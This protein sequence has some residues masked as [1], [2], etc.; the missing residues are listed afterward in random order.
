V[1]IFQNIGSA[2]AAIH[3]TSLDQVHLHELGGVDT[4]VDVVGALVGLQALEVNYIVSSPVPL[5]RGFIRGAHGE[6]PLPAPATVALL[7]GVPITSSPLQIETVTP[8]GAA[9]LAALADE[10]GP[11]P[12]MQLDQVGYGAG[13]RDL[14]V[15][16]VLRILIGT[17]QLPKAKKHLSPSSHH[18]DHTHTAKAAG[19]QHGHDH[20][21]PHEHTHD[22]IL[23]PHH[24]HAAPVLSAVKNVKQSGTSRHSCL[25]TDQL[26][27]LETNVDDLNP[28]FYEHV[29]DKL[30]AAGALDVFMAPIQ[31]KKNRPATLFR[32]LCQPAKIKEMTD[33]LFQETS[34]LGIRQHNVERHALPRTLHT[35]D[36]TYGE[37][38]V[39]VAQ[40]ENDTVKSA[41]E[42]D[43]CRR[44]A[45]KHGVP[46]REVY[47]AAHEVAKSEFGG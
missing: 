36:T 40:L 9:L 2:E 28:E 12:D 38:R 16:N 43:D 47:Q 15:P 4:I 19:L 41:P 11:I 45:E 44:L 23:N 31:M 1:A 20:P 25:D 21:H 17:S 24:S 3:G 14:P 13:S 29:M 18:P 26:T 7:K 46:L 34:T 30:F 42:Y 37:V 8:T 10:F 6:I 32:V 33:I 22:L 35:V 27:V 39:K 5:G